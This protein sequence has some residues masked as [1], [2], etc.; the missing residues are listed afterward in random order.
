[1]SL[2][3]G[4]GNEIPATRL[5]I[6][7]IPVSI[8]SVDLE[9]YI[10]R[11]GAKLRSP[12]F[13]ERVRYPNGELSRFASGRRFVWIDLP[14][15]PLPRTIRIGDKIA[16]LFY[17]EQPKQP[18][19]CYSCGKEGHKRGDATC[20]GH[21]TPGQYGHLPSFSEVAGRDSISQGSEDESIASEDVASVYLSDFH[22]E[23]GF[24]SL[25]GQSDQV[26]EDP[27]SES[28]EDTTKGNT[29]QL[30][31]ATGGDDTFVVPE[32]GKLASETPHTSVTVSLDQNKVIEQT[33]KSGP[34]EGCK[35]KKA[36]KQKGKKK[37]DGLNGSNE[38]EKSKPKSLQPSIS[39]IF[40][41]SDNIKGRKRPD[42]PSPSPE[43][44]ASKASQRAS[45]IP[46]N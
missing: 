45:K 20:M 10:K 21:S 42:H 28:E 13:W 40:T 30:G 17:R 44:E 1:M 39:D 31:E 27:A 16:T 19:K 38:N 37:E 22:D 11:A 8:A 41:S 12:L 34:R 36:R 24:P 4:Q 33:P 9:G 18:I 7:N 2:R 3:D 6:G 46:K 32:D 25:R 23:N 15:V 35:S 43:A 14:T 5:I 29:S 26:D